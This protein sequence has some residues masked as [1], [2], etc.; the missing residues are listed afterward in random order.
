VGGVRGR[1]VGVWMD[2]LIRCA[3]FAA[4]SEQT[5]SNG[6]SGGQL[7]P[8]HLQHVA[9]PDPVLLRQHVRARDVAECQLTKCLGVVGA[10]VSLGGG[11]GKK[12]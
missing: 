3:Q 10:F 6:N 11:T 2:G 8:T 9:A 1:L 7:K 4:R 12:G 5:E